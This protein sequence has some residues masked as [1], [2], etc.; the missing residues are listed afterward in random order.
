M[1]NTIETKSANQ[2]YKESGSTLPFRQW[3]EREKAKG[4]FIPNINAN[5]EMLNVMGSGSEDT[6]DKK[7]PLLRNIAVVVVIGVLGY[8]VYRTIKAKTNEG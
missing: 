6:E 7:S 3:I 1:N 8:F 4:I 5:N 2:L